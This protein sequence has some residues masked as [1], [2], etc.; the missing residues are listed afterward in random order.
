MI[1]YAEIILLAAEANLEQEK[2]SEAIELTN[3]V[4]VRNERSVLNGNSSKTIIQEAILEEWEKD[5]AKEGVWF[6]ALKRFNLA[7][8]TLE[9]PEYMILLP[10]P[11]RELD[12]NPYMS[13]NPGY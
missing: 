8:K 4:R 9:I 10:I 2:R 12:Y 11:R 6:S 13:Q 5:L 1:R 7:E 3:K